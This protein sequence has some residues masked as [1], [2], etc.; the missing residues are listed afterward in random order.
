[1]N[2]DKDVLRKKLLKGSYFTIDN[3][4]DISKAYN[5]NFDDKIEIK[6]NK[7]YLLQQLNNKLKNVCNNQQC[8]LKLKFM[9]DINDKNL[10]KNI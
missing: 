8:W 7:R 5:S 9:K 6:E 4:I 2:Q 3:L 1:M 10:L